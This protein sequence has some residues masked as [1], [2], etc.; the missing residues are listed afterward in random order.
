MPYLVIQSGENVGKKYPLDSEV[1]IG[2]VQKN[3]SRQAGVALSDPRVSRDHAL[4]YGQSGG[5]VLKDL[6]STNGT[7]LNNRKVNGEVYLKNG[8][9]IRIGMHWIS[10]R[11]ESVNDD[12]ETLDDFEIIEKIGAG[13]MADVYRARQ[14]SLDR[15]VAVKVLPKALLAEEKSLAELFLNEARALA[16]LD[17]PNVIKML[18]FQSTGQATYFV[19]EYVDAPSLA[20]ALA[21]R[22]FDV[23]DALDVM[24]QIGE[25]LKAAH[26]AGVIHL[27]LKPGNIILSENRAKI[28]DFGLAKI[29]TG[30]SAGEGE[31]SFI[32]TV[33]YISPE[34]IE[35]KNTSPA[36]DVYSLGIILYE[37]LTG[38]VPFRS[39]NTVATINKHLN[40]RPDPV[41]MTNRAV[42]PAV[43]GLV[44]KMLEKDPAKRYRDGAE[45]LEALE[46]ARQGVLAHQTI[47][48]GN[49][50]SWPGIL[51]HPWLWW[52]S[53]TAAAV[54]I[55]I[56]AAG[57]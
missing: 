19:T 31:S 57:I 27:D 21:R 37:M 15:I 14:K 16:R 12:F 36:S 11:D 30:G 45:F 42:S 20:D 25:G 56:I 3:K 26:R 2:R 34:Q 13:G 7:F 8:D 23:L 1:R 50:F 39:D 52:V 18:D 9:L 35:G 47:G 33:E 22:R 6:G 41:A 4:I 51:W 55:K 54:L 32:G 28:I 49:A 38:A 44:Q 29:Y 48:G 43:D 24:R 40:D 53:L 46:S 10:F 17:H 5:F